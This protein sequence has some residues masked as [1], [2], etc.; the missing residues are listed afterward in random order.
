MTEPSQIIFII[1]IVLVVCL[2]AIFVF[3]Y[4]RKNMSLA[5]VSK[6]EEEAKKILNEAQKDADSKRK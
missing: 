3:I 1:A 5:N 6:S 2:V 4:T